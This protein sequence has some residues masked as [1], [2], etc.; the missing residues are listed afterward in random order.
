[1]MKYIALE[2][3]DD[4]TL[5]ELFMNDEIDGI[6]LGDAFC[7]KRMFEYGESGLLG[8]CIQ[9][10]QMGKKVIL[11]TPCYMTDRIFDKNITFIRYLYDNKIS[12]QYL[13]QDIGFAHK[14]SEKFPDAD[15]IWSQNSTTRNL[16]NNL[17]FYR[18]IR[19]IGVNSVEVVARKNI[20]YLVDMGFKIY[21]ANEKISFNTVNRE[22]YYMHQFDIY[23]GDCGRGCI[24][25]KVRMVNNVCGIDMSISGYQLGRKYIKTDLDADDYDD[26]MIAHIIY[27]HD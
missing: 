8:A 16:A 5:H 14:L 24:V 7:Q 21:T 15:I 2:K 22:C 23:D 26:N 10:A 3:Y 27:M 9:T 11:Q 6:V 18:F 17:S 13:V 1:M 12:T 20:P 19:T 4:T 25:D